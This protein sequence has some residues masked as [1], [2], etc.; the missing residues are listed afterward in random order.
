MADI[1]YPAAGN[2]ERLLKDMGDGTHEQRIVAFIAGESGAL[3][4][5][6]GVAGALVIQG[7]VHRMIH[8]GTLYEIG[9]VNETV[10][11]NGDIE[12]LVTTAVGQSAHMR[13]IAAAGGDARIALFENPTVSNVGTGLTEINRN[14]L[15]SNTAETAVTHTPTTSA[16]GTQLMDHLLPGGSGFF[17]GGGGS[18]TSFEEFILKPNEQYLFRITNIAGTAQPVGASLTFYEPS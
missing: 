11:D 7:M 12:L 10:A 6:D 14:R 3:A 18:E 2:A 5:V 17:G 9:Y 16:D 4:E 13:F 15:S 1:S 8:L